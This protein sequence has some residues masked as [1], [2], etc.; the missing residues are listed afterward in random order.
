MQTV[1]EGACASPYFHDARWDLRTGLELGCDPSRVPE[2]GINHAQILAASNGTR[3]FWA[4]VVQ[5]FG[6]DDTF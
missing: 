3:I 2:N 6:F 5:D 1:A 4:Q